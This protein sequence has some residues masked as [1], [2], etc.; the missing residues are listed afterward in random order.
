MAGIYDVYQIPEVRKDNPLQTHFDQNQLL[1]EAV[2]TGK[3]TPEQY[4]ILG[5]YDVQKNL[6]PGN[7]ILGGIVNLGASIPYNIYQSIKT[8]QPFSDVFGDVYRNVKGGLGLFSPELKTAYNDIM[9][10]KTPQNVTQ[11]ANK[12]F[13]DTIGDMVFTT[14]NAD[15][16]P[17]EIEKQSVERGVQDFDLEGVRNIISQMEEEKSNYIERPENRFNMDGILQNLG[18]YAKDAAGRY[19]GSQALGGAGAMLLGPIGG[20]VG[21]IAGLLGGGDL[22]NQNSYSQQMYNNLTPEGKTYASSLYGPG[23]ILQG[24]NQISAFG[25]GTLGT[26]GNIL[27]NNP[28][29]SATRK[30]AFREAADKYISGIDP[31]QQGINAVTKTGTHAYDDITQY[32]QPSDGDSGGGGVSGG[33]TYGSVGS[34]EDFGTTY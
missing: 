31:T 14:A 33:Q 32:I 20:L 25:R 24:Y 34:Y 4:N 26:I 17:T 30:S 8:D 27:A 5:G 9:A 7:P 12:N 2:A 10:G 15:A 11:L 28:N 13:I 19:I 23:G 16:I 22:F 21:G 1:K 18:N 3:I 6:T 29:M